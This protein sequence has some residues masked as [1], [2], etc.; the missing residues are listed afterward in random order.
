MLLNEHD[1]RERWC[2]QTI[3]TSIA[4][5]MATECMAWRWGEYTPQICDKCGT[6]ESEYRDTPEQRRGFCG[7]AGMPKF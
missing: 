3:G 2:Q 7:L 4:K 6:A 5:C 1:A